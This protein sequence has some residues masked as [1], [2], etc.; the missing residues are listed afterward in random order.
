[1]CRSTAQLLRA[2]FDQLGA[3]Q[4]SARGIDISSSWTSN[5]RGYARL[6]KDL[7]KR[8]HAIF[9]WRSEGDL[10]P[11][12]KS[13]QVDLGADPARQFDHFPRII[14]AVIHSRQQH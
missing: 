14:R 4:L 1:M 12:I 6:D 7:L 3:L 9:G 11:G 13:D 10:R 2:D 8:E 5:E